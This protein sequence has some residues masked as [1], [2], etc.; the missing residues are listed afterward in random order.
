MIFRLGRT[1]G[2]K[3]NTWPSNERQVSGTRHGR[4]TTAF[5]ATQPRSH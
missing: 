3:L 5:D 1:T 4:V 2:T